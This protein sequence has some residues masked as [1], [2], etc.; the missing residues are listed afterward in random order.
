MAADGS[1]RDSVHRHRNGSLQAGLA[2]HDG[3]KRLPESRDECGEVSTNAFAT[4]ALQRPL[5]LGAD[6]S[7][8]ST[9][10]YIEG[11]N[12]T[13]GGARRPP[14]PAQRRALSHPAIATVCGL[15]P[16]KGVDHLIDAFAMVHRQC[17]TAHL[18]IV[19][20]G[21]FRAAYE[22]QAAEMQAAPVIT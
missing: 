1:P 6:I 5:D 19:G 17:P 18:Y 20:D 8:Y 22:Q 7:V 13:I 16:R 14:A 2:S 9:T 15:Q 3:G 21:P 11:H 12:G 10:K 4:S